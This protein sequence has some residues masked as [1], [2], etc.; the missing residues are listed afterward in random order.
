M[1][2]MEGTGGDKIDT[3]VDTSRTTIR[4]LLF[5]LSENLSESNLRKRS[6]YACVG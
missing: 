6:L 3:A 4:H 1:I 5:D 2:C